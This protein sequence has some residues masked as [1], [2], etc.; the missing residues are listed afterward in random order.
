MSKRTIPCD[1][2]DRVIIKG[3]VNAINIDPEGNELYE[4][5]ID[6]P[7]VERETKDRRGRARYA[8]DCYDP[9]P[10]IYLGSDGF[11]VDEEA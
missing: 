10:R 7:N 6:R 1:I 2:G 5:I 4:I 11:T 3:V 9:D 8:R